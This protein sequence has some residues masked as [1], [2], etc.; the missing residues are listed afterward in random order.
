MRSMFTANLIATAAL[1]IP[2]P[3]LAQTTITVLGG[4]SNQY[5]KR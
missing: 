4:F 5:Q 3:A 2:L 1:L